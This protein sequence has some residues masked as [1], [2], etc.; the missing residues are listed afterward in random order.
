MLLALHVHTI[1][2]DCSE[3][4]IHAIAEFCRK[5]GIEAVGITDHNSI[6]GALEL[7]DHAPDIRVIIGEEIS[8]KNGEIIGLFLKERIEP[9]QKLMDTCL[10]IK[11]QG[12]LI[13]VPHPFDRLKTKRVRIKYLRSVLDLVDIIEVHNSK[14]SLPIYNTR[15]RRYARRHGKIGA[16]GSDSH[17]VASISAALNEIEPFDGPED[18]L[19]KLSKARFRTGASSLLATWWVRV[20]KIF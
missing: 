20:R 1:H 17:Y 15:A 7:M 8:T 2:S 5:A 13:Y 14:I 4:K 9:G 11:E 12:G 6:D 16:V 19:K 10:Q 3:S 18:F